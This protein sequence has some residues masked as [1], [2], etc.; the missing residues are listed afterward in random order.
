MVTTESLI[1]AVLNTA[2]MGV[3]SGV[4]W[5]RAKTEEK[6]LGNDATYRAYSAWMKQRWSHQKLMS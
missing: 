5:W 6:H 1:D 3:V 4:Y 2:I